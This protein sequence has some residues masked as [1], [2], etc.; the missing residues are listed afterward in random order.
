MN[1]SWKPLR[2]GAVLALLTITYGFGMGMVFGGFEPAIKAGL[3]AD[4][5]AALVDVYNGDLRRM[6]KVV[7]KAWVYMKRS[8]LHAG[9]IGTAVLAMLSLLSAL[10]IKNRIKMGM[11]I[12][13]G[14]GGFGYS[15]FWLFAGLSA[16]SAGAP[17]IAKEALSWLAAPSALMLFGSTVMLLILAIAAA[18]D[19]IPTALYQEVD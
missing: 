17:R 13:L 5:E 15:L 16:P 4:G 3:Q 12:A 8:H 2:F 9:A 6:D 7:R 1:K 18:F 14:L 10:A 11:S 19:K